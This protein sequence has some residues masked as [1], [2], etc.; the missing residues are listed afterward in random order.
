MSPL[1][2]DDELVFS[3]SSL[4]SDPSPPSPP[5]SSIPC[6]FLMMLLWEVFFAPI[7]FLLALCRASQAPTPSGPSAL[8]RLN[9]LTL[10]LFSLK[11]GF[12][13]PSGW[14]RMSR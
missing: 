8:P 3:S 2:V 12:I 10:R 5:S 14:N 6:S 9:T 4:M 11:G 7:P 1:L 13:F